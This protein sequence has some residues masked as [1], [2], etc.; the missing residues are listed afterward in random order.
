[1]HGHPGVGL[2]SL[3][4]LLGSPF[5][6]TSLE[7]AGDGLRGKRDASIVPLGR[8]FTINDVARRPERRQQIDHA[9]VQVFAESAPPT[10][11]QFEIE[12]RGIKRDLAGLPARVREVLAQFLPVPLRP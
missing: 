3:S 4:I 1:M 11:R 9:D 5:A 2:P 8:V 10:L 12:R 6:K 7:P